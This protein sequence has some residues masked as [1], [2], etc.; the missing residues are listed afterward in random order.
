M[1]FIPVLSL[2]AGFFLNEEIAFKRVC[3][4]LGYKHEGWLFL[5][6]ETGI[7]M[8][9]FFCA[10]SVIKG[11]VMGNLIKLYF[12]G[13]WC[14]PA[15]LFFLGN[16]LAVKQANGMSYSTWLS[17]MGLFIS[18]NFYIYQIPL[19]AFVVSL[20]MV[21]NINTAVNLWKIFFVFVL[22]INLSFKDFGMWL[23]III[24]SYYFLKKNVTF[25]AKL[26]K[27]FCKETRM[28]G[29]R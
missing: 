19:T 1:G 10:F 2:A 25:Y 6:Q 16:V 5:Y 9:V 27:I 7:Y 17:L 15:V 18:K 8:F 11:W 13:L 22:F 29:E 20:L 4:C 14:I 26:N 24:I 3:V 12:E 21:R 23:V 28:E